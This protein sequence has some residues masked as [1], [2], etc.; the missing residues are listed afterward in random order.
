MTATDNSTANRPLT[1]DHLKSR[2]KPVV[3]R[4]HI[5]MDTD[6]VDAY[7]KAKGVHDL[8]KLRLIRSTDSEVAIKEEKESHEALKVAE[9]AIRVETVIF[10]FRSIGRVKFDKI[11]SD[12]PAT[13][14][15]LEKA[16]ATGGN[17]AWNEETYPLAL[18]QACLLDPPLTKEEI[19]DLWT[20]DNWSPAE[21]RDLF[22]A[23]QAANTQRK[24]V[25]L[26]NV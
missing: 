7:E 20:D 13:P 2:K 22:F 21:H 1:Y 12:H 10:S 11:I 6:L 17:P 26:G 8:A 14:K 4:V 16:Q 23:A 5:C 25:E 15:Q 24:A 9:D 3:V 18:I 19:K